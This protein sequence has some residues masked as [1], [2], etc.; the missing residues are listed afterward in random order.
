MR[1]QKWCFNV[2]GIRCKNEN[3]HTIVK[4]FAATIDTDLDLDHIPNI[5][6][7]YDEAKTIAK[8]KRPST[9]PDRNPIYHV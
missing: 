9:S 1:P 5:V 8:M 7:Q 3:L 4:L 6:N 2:T